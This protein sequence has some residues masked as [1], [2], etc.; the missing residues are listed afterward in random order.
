MAKPPTPTL[1]LTSFSPWS[2]RARWAL[3]H[4]GIQ[5]RREE[6]VVMLGEPLLRLRL[7]KLR[8]K[9]SIPIYVDGAR[10]FFDS[11]DIARHADAIGTGTPLFPRGAER[12]VDRWTTRS[13]D[14][15]EA[16]RKLL[17][18]RLLA[19]KAARRES[20]PKAIPAVLRGLLDP[21]AR[22]ATRFVG[23]KYAAMAN[24][25]AGAERTM[26]S[27]LDVVRARLATG[28]TT[29]LDVGFTFA[30]ITIAVSLQGIRPVEHPAIR[31]GPATRAAWTHG[32]L[33]GEYPDLLAW[34]DKLYAERRPRAAGAAGAAAA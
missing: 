6:H 29:M 24:D 7:R 27:V 3:D 34:R 12:E 1:H 22:T 33:A 13:N 10:T 14:L 32:P 26:R 19:D 31:L 25:P 2:E 20:L 4:H 17:L 23:K 8:G 11:V 30:D 15:L 21:V 16:G 18:P 28:A 5:Y 9:L